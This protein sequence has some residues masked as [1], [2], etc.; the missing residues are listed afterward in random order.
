[1]QDYRP[2]GV[3]PIKFT[4]ADDEN[5]FGVR[6]FEEILLETGSIEEMRTARGNEGVP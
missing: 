5:R 3:K 1:M 6:L 4:F 2:Y